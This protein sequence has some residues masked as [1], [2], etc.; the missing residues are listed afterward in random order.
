MPLTFDRT[1]E[2]RHFVRMAAAIGALACVCL[3][4]CVV[5]P[6][7]SDLEQQQNQ[8]L[9]GTVLFG[10]P[11][12]SSE[13]PDEDVLELTDDM[14]EFLDQQI[15][16]AR[17]PVVRFRRLFNGLK[18]NGYFNSFYAA[19]TTRTA[20]ETFH[21]K[22]GNCLSYTNMF[23]ALAREAGLDARFQI[24]IVPP[25]WDADSG[26]LIRYTHINVIMKGFV[27]DKRYGEDFNVDFND[28]LPDPDYQRYEISDAEATSL[29]YANRS[30]SLM[31]AGEVRSAF[32]HLKK[33]IELSPRDANLW[34]NLGALYAKQEQFDIAIGA[35]EL[36]LHFDPNNRGAISG[37]ARSHDLLG[38]VEE[39]E[40]YASKSRRYREKNPFY[41]YAIAQAEFENARYDSALLSINT[42]LDLKYRSGRF[43]FFKGLT[44]QRLGEADAAELSFRRATRYRDYRKVASSRQFQLRIPYAPPDDW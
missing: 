4:G 16:E 8:V 38:N 23:I 2:T 13:I 10:E 41:H 14:I 26:Y 42:A 3:S 36:A 1:V 43:H 12:S 21:H 44:E 5:L 20:A 28:V 37:L 32:V 25:N 39:S 7:V 11:V 35:Y 27:F 34:I 18:E 15:R 40:L 9:D 24:V 29:F 17:M 22:S 33:A 30:V 19:D 6:R 31:R